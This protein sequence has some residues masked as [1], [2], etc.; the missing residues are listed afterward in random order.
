MHKRRSI[1]VDIDKVLHSIANR[2]TVLGKISE[3][4]AKNFSEHTLT[5]IGTKQI[6]ELQNDMNQIKQLLN[7]LKSS[8]SKEIHS[9]ESAPLLTLKQ[10]YE[11]LIKDK[12]IL[13][14]MGVFSITI[15]AKNLD[16]HLVNLVNF[17]PASIYKQLGYY[18]VELANVEATHITIDVVGK[19]NE[20][21]L[22]I[23][24]NGIHPLNMT[25]ATI[26]NMIEKIRR[27]FDKNFGVNFVM[28]SLDSLLNGGRKIVL[29]FKL[30][31]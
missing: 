16:D 12:E 30:S 4:C 17:Y 21:S 15:R 26:K 1:D 29:D 9:L 5:Q 8:Y 19:E 14:E 27:D 3:Y 18:F 10:W 22:S 23:S 13:C 6:I 11:H 20:L 25:N 31:T 2:L 7:D 28:I 24:D